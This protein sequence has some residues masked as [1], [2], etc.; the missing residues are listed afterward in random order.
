MM[1]VVAALG[2]AYVSIS[3]PFVIARHS[4][5]SQVLCNALKHES[6]INW[7]G[8]GRAGVVGSARGSRVCKLAAWSPTTASI[9][10]ETTELLEKYAAKFKAGDINGDGMLQRDELRA[11]LEKVGDGQETV[12]MH[13]LTDADLDDLFEQYDRDRNGAISLDEFMLLAQDNVFLT[14]ELSAYK[15]AFNAVD[16][17]GDGFIG[18][19]EMCA[20]LTVLGSPLQSYEEITRLMHKY[21]KDNSGE[22]KSTLAVE[23]ILFFATTP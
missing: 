4:A 22:F 14:K 23:N 5:Q 2:S 19:N 7:G 3:N 16:V 9:D 18:P 12:P 17:G 13:W 6:K 8:F 11:L 1:P 15:S 20:V 10:D 21:D